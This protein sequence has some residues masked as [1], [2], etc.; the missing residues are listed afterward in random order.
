LAADHLIADPQ[1]FAEAVARAGE[2][3]EQGCLVTFGIKPTGPDTGF[4]YIEADGSKV[5]RFVEKPCEA[6]AREYL[7]SGNFLWNAGMFCFRAGDVL[8]QLGRYAPE[9]LAA[10]ESCVAASAQGVD[11][12]ADGYV[13]ELDA[14]VFGKVPSISIDYALMEKSDRVA[15][16]ACDIGWNDVGSWAALGSLEQEDERGNHVSRKS[17][18]I[19]EDSAN[20]DIYGDSRLVAALGLDNLLIVDTPDALLVADKSRVQDVKQ[21]YDR[22]KTEG[23]EV[24]KH[25]RTIH[26][27][28]GSYTLL[29]VGSRFKIKRLEIKPGAAISLQLHHHR[30]E[31]WIVVSGMAEVTCGEQVFL[32]DTNESTYIKAGYKHRVA[33]RGLITLVIIEVQ[34]GDY[35]GEDDII[36]FD[37][38]YGRVE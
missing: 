24:Y 14:D 10:V 7:D 15:V 12:V 16:V 22:L 25:H 30:S 4:G 20:C 34:S 23:H 17:E 26:R 6:K 13:L 1:A 27:P 11:W 38:I 21:I 37:D 31:H 2:L 35:L 8:S 36:R 33:N 3:V 18:V 19:L 32:V 28:W 29:E 5:L 9:L